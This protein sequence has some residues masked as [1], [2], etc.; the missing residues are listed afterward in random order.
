MNLCN[1]RNR[2]IK[3]Q[4]QWKVLTGIDSG[5]NLVGWVSIKQK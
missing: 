3:K 4:E 2:E 1:I 5:N